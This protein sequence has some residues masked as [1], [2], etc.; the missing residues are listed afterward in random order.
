MSRGMDR[1]DDWPVSQSGTGGGKSPV[2]PGSVVRERDSS[3]SAERTTDRHETRPSPAWALPSGA[4]RERVIHDRHTYTLRGTESRV[5]DTLATFRV[6]LERDLVDDVYA[7]HRARMGKELSSLETQGIVTRRDLAADQAGHHVRVVTL[8][9]EGQ[10]LVTSHRTASRFSSDPGRP[11]HAGWG[12]ACEVVHDA[13]PTGCI[14][15]RKS[16]SCA[17]AGRFGAWCWTT[18]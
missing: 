6:V 18:N 9:R 11:V 12:K 5:L 4:R 13:S 8:T 16:A 17:R 10:D 2:S 14:S 1:Q 15:S 7:G 3:R